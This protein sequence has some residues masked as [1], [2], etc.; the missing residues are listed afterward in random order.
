MNAE[1]GIVQ[2]MSQCPKGCVGRRHPKNLVAARSFVSSQARGHHS[3]CDGSIS[4]TTRSPSLSTAANWTSWR[5]L[6]QT[7]NHDLLATNTTTST[8]H[9]TAT[10]AATGTQKISWQRDLSSPHKH[11]G[12]IAPDV[13]SAPHAAT[14]AHR[15]HAPQAIGHRSEFLAT[16][17]SYAAAQG[18]D[19]RLEYPE[20]RKAREVERQIRERLE[21]CD[22]LSPQLTFL[23]GIC[24]FQSVD[25]HGASKGEN[26]E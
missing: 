9:S 26:L 3:S 14:I 17:C 23:H 24:L 13:S 4:S 12:I 2:H 16:T 25:V 18:T 8:A 11:V 22:T 7:N 19:D 20:P 15:P 10:M 1:A 6:E 5:G 21:V